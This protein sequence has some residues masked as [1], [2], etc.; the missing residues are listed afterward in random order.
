MRLGLSLVCAF[1]GCHSDV[2]T[3]KTDADTAHVIATPDGTYWESMDF[4]TDTKLQLSMTGSGN[5][6]DATHD[7]M[8]AFAWDGLTPTSIE[9]F[10]CNPA[11]CV[12]TGLIDVQFTSADKFT[13]MV[14]PDDTTVTTWNLVKSSTF[15]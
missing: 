10:S 15:P 2:D 7:S 13:A 9:I 6:F 11:P 3:N 14:P 1:I 4:Q 12:M 8:Q 5:E